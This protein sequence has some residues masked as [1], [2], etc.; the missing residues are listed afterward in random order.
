MAEIANSSEMWSGWRDR[1]REARTQPRAAELLA[2]EANH[3]GE[4]MLALSLAESALRWLSLTSSPREAVPLRK[5]MALALARSGAT[6][7]AM[8]VL[9]DSMVA[10][11]EDAETL[12]LLGRLHKD[13]AQRASTAEMSA[14]HLRQALDFYARGFA[15]EQ[16]AYCGVNA[17]V[18]AVRTGDLVLARQTA[19]RILELAPQEDRLWSAATTAMAW[20]IRGESERA[21]AALRQADRAGEMRRS[22]L[23]VV[24]REAQRL[25]EA[26]HGNASEYDEC[27]RPGAVAIFHG[28]TGN[29]GAAERAKLELW[30]KANRVVCAWSAAGC[31]EEAAFVECA[32]ALGI[33]TC[34]V[35]PETQP[36]EVCRKAVEGALLVDAGDESTKEDPGAAE[37]ARHV[38]AAR[39]AARAASWGVPLLP[40]FAGSAVPECWAKISNEPFRLCEAEQEACAPADGAAPTALLCVRVNPSAED[41]ANKGAELRETWRKHT[42]RCGSDKANGGNFLF[43]WP[44]MAEAGRAAVDLHRRLR[45]D[46]APHACSFILHASAKAKATTAFDGWARRVYAGRIHATGRFADLAAFEGSRDFDLCYAGTV[47]CDA[48][49]LGQRLYQLRERGA[50][51]TPAC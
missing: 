43:G 21:R 45:G 25:A 4:H 27:F 32:A 50:S 23:A 38:A 1:V 6:E 44:T 26:L 9:R 41:A 2:R 47:D 14:G 29:L 30:L 13:F 28:R 35:L 10:V 12:G 11:P 20:I 36:R 42:A 39:A 17:A 19:H 24:Q 37:L 8:E 31:G 22:D 7:E 46:T 15:M 40:V 49:P 3:R 34:V 51:K 33:E 16:S 18:L 48:E 5:Q